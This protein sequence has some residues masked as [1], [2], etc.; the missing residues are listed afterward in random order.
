MAVAHADDLRDQGPQVRYACDRESSRHLVHLHRRWHS[1]DQP[2]TVLAEKQ[3][4]AARDHRCVPGDL[5]TGTLLKFATR[6]LVFNCSKKT[7]SVRGACRRDGHDKVPP[8][9]SPISTNDPTL[10]RTKLC[11]L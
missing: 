5:T 4:G 9:I 1:V 2:H 10:V 6:L 11:S 3:G 7:T 8:C